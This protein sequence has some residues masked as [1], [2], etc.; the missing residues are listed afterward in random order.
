M[1]RFILIALSLALCIYGWWQIRDYAW[2]PAEC[3]Q[4]EPVCPQ[5]ERFRPNA[6]AGVN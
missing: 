4:M 1:K 3:A 5:G 6:S 2:M